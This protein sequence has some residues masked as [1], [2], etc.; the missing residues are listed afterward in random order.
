MFSIVYIKN[1]VFYFFYMYMYFYLIVM[2]NN[3]IFYNCIKV[4]NF[5]YWDR[6]YYLKVL[7]VF[8]V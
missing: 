6:I 5:N 8:I 7:F 1:N 4:F 3:L 2:I